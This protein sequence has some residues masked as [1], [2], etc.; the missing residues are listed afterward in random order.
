MVTKDACHI[1]ITYEMHDY[2]Q[3][4]AQFEHV[5]GIN[6]VQNAAAKVT[7]LQELASLNIHIS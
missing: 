3:N 4:S 5:K 7:C 2:L 6:S 1:P